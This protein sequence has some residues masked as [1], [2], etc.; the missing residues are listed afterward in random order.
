MTEKANYCTKTWSPG[1]K[2]TLARAQTG[3]PAVL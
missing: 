1:T 3:E 2:E